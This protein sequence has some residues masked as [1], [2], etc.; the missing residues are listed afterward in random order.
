M[1]SI[2]VLTCSALTLCL[3]SCK[4]NGS[5]SDQ[6]DIAIAVGAL[7]AS[8]AEGGETKSINDAVEL[9]LGLS[10][11]TATADGSY[12]GTRGGFMY[13]YSLTCMADTV[14]L[15]ACS[16][17]TSTANL[18]VEWSGAIDTERFDASVL[19]TGDWT[20]AL[21]EGDATFNGTGTFEVD[22]MFTNYRGTSSVTWSLDYQASYAGVTWDRVG[23]TFMG[24]TITYDV[25]ASRMREGRLSSSNAELDVQ[26]VVVFDAQGGATITIDEEHSYQLN[27]INGTVQKM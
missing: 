12:E 4:K 21:T 3:G 13:K 19:R 18:T 7:V 11:L 10:S 6:D 16:S 23:Q 8:N 1:K 22:S 14:T 24:G 25:A 27:T 20:L 26:V 17:D 15:E 9:S 2:L 5:S